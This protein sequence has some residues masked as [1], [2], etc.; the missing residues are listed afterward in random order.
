MLTNLKEI[1]RDNLL[2]E[3][4]P[5]GPRGYRFV[6]ITCVDC[7]DHFE[8][9]YHFDKDYELTTLRLNLAKGQKLPSISDIIP[10]AVLVENE[11]RDLFGIEVKGLILDYE[12]RF[13]LS[14]DAPQAPFTVKDYPVK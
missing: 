2:N 11:I 6:T 5:M 13:M 10:A 1:N 8:I 9:M 12:G 4:A 14:E 3:I 7:G